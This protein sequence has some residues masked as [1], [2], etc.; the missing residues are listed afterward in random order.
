MPLVSTSANLGGHKPIKTYRACL[1]QF[2][3]DVSVLRG[4]IGKRRSP[5]TIIDLNTGKV[6]R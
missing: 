5:S 1:R 4:R 3:G 2:G 6:L